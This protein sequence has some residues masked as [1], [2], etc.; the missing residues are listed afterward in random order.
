MHA[1]DLLSGHQTKGEGREKGEAQVLKCRQA[2]K[3]AGIVESREAEENERERGSVR[4]EMSN[5]TTTS[6]TRRRRK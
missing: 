1:A 3:E 5:S 4:R 6:R 2:E